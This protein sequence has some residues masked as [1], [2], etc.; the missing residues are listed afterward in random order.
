M[1][2]IVINDWFV[3]N[4][5]ILTPFYI[6]YYFL[7]IILYLLLYTIQLYILYINNNNNNIYIYI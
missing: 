6:I 1:N 3:V 2:M 4:T 5:K 7:Y